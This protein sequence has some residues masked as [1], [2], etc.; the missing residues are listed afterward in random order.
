MSKVIAVAAL[1]SLALALTGS[2]C[3]RPAAS[4]RPAPKPVVQQTPV[5]SPSAADRKLIKR[6][7]TPVSPFWVAT[8]VPDVA[9]ARREFPKGLFPTD[10]AGRKLVG[11]V[12]E[13]ATVPNVSPTADLQLVYED[14]LLINEA[15]HGGPGHGGPSHNPSL[16][17]TT[18]GNALAEASLWAPTDP[19]ND[20]NAPRTALVT[21]LAPRTALVTWLDDVGMWS[22]SGRS[23]T[24]ADVVRIARSLVP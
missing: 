1:V 21:W 16:E 22:V 12:L 10:T 13:K 20:P 4:A 23:L 7:V 18:V 24:K 15:A 19:N 2:G 8:T 14:G 6:L 3:A 11:I 9:T 5:A 17:T